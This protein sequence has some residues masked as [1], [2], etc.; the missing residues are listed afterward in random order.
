MITYDEMPDDNADLADVNVTF[1]RLVRDSPESC[2]TSMKQ[3]LGYLA[4]EVPGGRSLSGADLE[5][6]RTADVEGTAYWIWR[7]SEPTGGDEAFVVTSVKPDGTVTIT[8]D[9]NHY[10][11]SPEQFILGDYYNVF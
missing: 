11:L 10:D 9:T 5:F 2:P 6:L 3:I 8:Y 4:R 1:P 7:F